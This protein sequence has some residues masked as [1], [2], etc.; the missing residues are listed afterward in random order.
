[1]YS[2][3]PGDECGKDNQVPIDERAENRT[4]RNAL[5]KSRKEIRINQN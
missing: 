4:S 3:S 2:N 5:I 1:M